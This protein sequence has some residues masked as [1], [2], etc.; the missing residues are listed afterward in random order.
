MTLRVYTDHYNSHR[1][2]RALGFKPPEAANRPRLIESNPPGQIQQPAR[3]GGLING[4][5]GA[6]DERIH[7]PHD[8]GAM[9]GIAIG[10]PR[11]I[12]VPPE[13]SLARERSCGAVR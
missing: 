4:Y 9:D 11:E 3:L 10:E 8:G 1:P 12:I 13:N 6:P 2:H 5:P 7:V